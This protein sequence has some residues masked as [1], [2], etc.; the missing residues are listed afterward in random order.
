MRI[1]DEKS[2]KMRVGLFTKMLSDRS[3]YQKQSF[4]A[5]YSK[6]FYAITMYLILMFLCDVNCEVFWV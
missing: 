6:A 2:L 5:P 3:K 1:T 4:H